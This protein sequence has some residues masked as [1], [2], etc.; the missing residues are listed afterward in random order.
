MSQCVHELDE[1][2]CSIC[3]RI[4]VRERKVPAAEERAALLFDYA[5]SNPEWTL[6]EA[7]A[8]FGWSEQLVSQAIRYLREVL[9]DDT[10]NLV[11]DRDADGAYRYK[12]VGTLEESLPWANQRLKSVESQLVTVANVTASICNATR[13]NSRDGRRA[14]L[15]AAQMNILQLQLDNLKE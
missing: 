2:T 13:A 4:E 7:C 5:A 1:G 14:R 3:L 11:V 15:I 6:Q 9:A 10:I 8:A 12:L